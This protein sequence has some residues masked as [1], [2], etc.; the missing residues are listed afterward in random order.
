MTNQK[1]PYPQG[2]VCVSGEAG[3]IIVGP[4]KPDAREL[5]PT[6]FV[7]AF[8]VVMMLMAG[9]F[10]AEGMTYY[11]D[12]TAGNDLNS[13][14]RPGT[15]WKNC[16]GMSAYLGTDILRPGD[17]VYFNRSDTWLVAGLQGIYL[18]GGVTYTGN[19]W[20]AGSGKARIR[21]DSDLDAGV[22]RF[23]DHSTY[24]TVFEGFDVDGNGKVTT[25]ADINHRYWGLMNGATKRIQDCEVHHTWSR[26]AY[27]Q[28][29][30]G[31][32]VSNSGG[33]GG[34]AENVEII[35][36]GVHDTSRDAICLY[37]GDQNE[38]C[39]IKNI[40]VRGCEVYNTGQDPDYGAGAAILVKGYV[41]D[42]YIENNYAH[43][44]KGAV[45]L[46]NGNETRHYGFGPANIHIR[47][48]IFTGN[49]S[50]GAIRIYDGRSGQD[51]K[52]LKIYGNLV[53]NNTIGGFYIGSDL[54]N[55]LSLR[56]YNNTFY[57]APVVILNNRASVR[58]FEFKN[59]I[60][61]YDGGVPLTDAEGQISSHSN[62]IF[63]R[64]SGTLVRS[65]GVD[66]SSSNLNGSYEETASSSNPLFKGIA[67]LPTGFTGAYGVDME[68]NKDG[69]RLE[70]DSPAISKGVVL[71]T[72][73]GSSINSVMRPIS[74][75]WDIGAYEYRTGAQPRIGTSQ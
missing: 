61:Y 53:Y 65:S 24:E 64:G 33:I 58:I 15:A 16:P 47:Y 39:R 29:K 62:N 22:V 12:Q 10:T 4:A 72:A 73:F 42:A 6:P 52:D 5:V 20:G 34:Y 60:V 57:N 13:G 19:S 35:N 54:G 38:N 70:Q 46:V 31:I 40:I 23:R 2:K 37:P 3:R 50:H 26:Q 28:Y 49:T 63:Y 1:T 48:N 55:R 11:V 43:D 30:Y 69:F 7:H 36:C 59:N 71:P 9:S 44:T 56:I 66:Y 8:V 67:D 41:Q 18:T 17:K 45:I 25:G 51:P 32:I 68:P 27:G 14:T 75:A 74:G 21:A